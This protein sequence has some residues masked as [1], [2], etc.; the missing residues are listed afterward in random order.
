MPLP[1]L[2]TTKH[3]GLEHKGRSAADKHLH[4]LHACLYVMWRK[5][6]DRQAVLK[7]Q[8]AA[9]TAQLANQNETA[10]TAAAAALAK[11][12]T[13]DSYPKEAQA[14]RLN[15]CLQ[16][17]EALLSES[18]ERRAALEGRQAAR[19]AQLLARQEHMAAA[20]QARRE[21][22]LQLIGHLSPVPKPVTRKEE[23]DQL[24]R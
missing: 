4:A 10:A 9:R 2:N 21:E 8:Q 3:F 23:L 7:K 18:S 5:S 19:A 11:V 16:I 6:S 12:S 1:K 22:R 17:L 13:A 15:T 14:D 20:A 24:R